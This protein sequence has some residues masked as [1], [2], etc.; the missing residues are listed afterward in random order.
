[1]GPLGL[2]AWWVQ[3]GFRSLD[4]KA[5]RVRPALLVKLALRRT[6]VLQVQRVREARLALKA[7]SE[8][9]ELQ[10]SADRRD[11]KERLARAVL[12]ARLA[13]KAWLA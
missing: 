3:M 1:M 5:Q 10:A 11:F 13:S 4:N 6:R 8:P 2:L 9:L 7:S 12:V